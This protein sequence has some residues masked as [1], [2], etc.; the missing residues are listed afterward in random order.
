MLYFVWRELMNTTMSKKHFSW[1]RA[2]GFVALVCTIIVFVFIVVESSLST[3][4]SAKLANSI[5]DLFRPAY[6]T[7]DTTPD[8]IKVR[9]LSLKAI[10]YTTG[11]AYFV[12][13]QYQ[14]SVSFSP[15][16]AEAEEYHFEVEEYGE[17]KTIEIDDN[18]LLTIV[19][20]GD[21][22]A[23][24]TA[25]LDSDSSVRS[26]TLKFW[27]HGTTRP[28]ENTQFVLDLRK[29]IGSSTI[30]SEA[31]PLTVGER[32]RFYVNDGESTRG[33]LFWYESSDTTVVKTNG[34]SV[35]AVGEGTA[36][37]RV[38]TDY[39]GLSWEY[40][41]DVH[42]K[43]APPVI[44]NPDNP[45]DPNPPAPEIILPETIITKS[46]IYLEVGTEFSYDDLDVSY[47]PA[48]ATEGIEITA[49]DTDLASHTKNGISPKEAG[50]YTITVHSVFDPTIE[51]EV[52]VI[53]TRPE[54]E[55]IDIN[56]N[57][58][59]SIYG[60]ATLKAYVGPK[61]ADD[62][63]VWSVVKGKAII[64]ED[65]KLQPKV[66][67]NVTVRA[68]SVT[69]PNMYSEKTFKVTLF[70]DFASF[71]RKI[72]GHFLIF[73]VLGLGFMA[74]YYLLAK[75]KY[76]APLFALL[77]GFATA[78]LSELLQMFADGRFSTFIDVMLDTLGVMT[79]M[80][81]GLVVVGIVCG[82][83]RVLSRDSFRKVAV[84]Y[85]SLNFTNAFKSK[86]T[87]D[88]LFS[89]DTYTHEPKIEKIPTATD[90]TL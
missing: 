75:R 34:C 57:S 89:A 68:T 10:G 50:S 37:I 79:G 56:T 77:S 62:E 36:T 23:K 71:A 22:S 20:M 33:N 72:M 26:N 65:G 12:G 69:N 46:V 73:A 84:A 31:N 1:M 9:A 45:D 25:V 49:E 86:S 85:R 52:T 80:G 27:A 82:L 59:I 43:A 29:S 5:S 42:V 7:I 24:I 47:Y 63:V 48:N 19:A 16:D 70:S 41:Y 67:G 21:G 81:F 14:L 66:L 44:P 55:F 18:D 64:D 28:D 87:L 8:T 90:A 83:W 40:F 74:T 54:V 76:L 6:N 78:C 11:D 88:M 15:R 53:I 30:G 51:T 13:D 2:L 35:Y 4:Q 58:T 60:D 17:L 32:A 39:K 3:A 61:Y 38:W